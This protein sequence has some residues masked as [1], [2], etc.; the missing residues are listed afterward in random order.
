[1]DKLLNSLVF[2]KGKPAR[3][4][5]I[6]K[7]KFNLEFLDGSIVK[8]RAKDFRFIYPEFSNVNDEC[9]SI[10]TTI[11]DELQSQQLSLKEITEWLFDEYSAQ[12]AWCSCLLA[13]DG[14]YFYW[15]K[16]VVYIRTKEQ[17]IS[18][19]SKREQQ[20]IEDENIK[21]CLDNIANNTF[22][23]KDIEYIK[24]VEKV[25]LN[26]SKH[27]KILAKLNIKNT[28]ENAH[29]MLLKIGYVDYFF[30][31]YLKRNDILEDED[32][33]DINIAKL[34]RKDLTHIK[35]FSIDSAH[36]KDSDD[37]IGIDDNKIWIHIADVSLVIKSHFELDDYAKQRV[38]SLY[39]PNK[40]FHML[41]PCVTELCALGINRK[42]NA[43]SIGF[44]LSDGEIKDIE[45]THSVIMVEKINYDYADSIIDTNK[46]L[47][48]LQNFANLH[49]NY[50]E[51]KG[52][53]NLNSTNINIKLKDKKIYIDLLKSSKSRELVAEMMIMAGRAVAKCS[54]ENKIV[55][56]YIGQDQVDI[57]QNILDNK[58]NLTLSQKFA[59]LKNFKKSTASINN[60]AHY[61]LGLD[62][63]LR[64]TSPLR[65]YLDLLAHQQLSNFIAGNKTLDNDDVKQIIGIIN[66]NSISVNMAIRFSYEHFKCL[67]LIQNPNWTG[68]GVVL[69]IVGNKTILA[70][71]SLDMRTYINFKKPKKLDEK[72]LLKVINVNLV[73]RLVDFS[74]A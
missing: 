41:P 20:L 50:R 45:I 47:L 19:K 39:L 43:L 42:S 58:T 55:M 71:P 29:R 22:A 32:I 23:K 6:T 21:N 62:S 74:P 52:A 60:A 2:F 25:A 54:L 36:T 8:A 73:E 51:S 48:K 28:P 69:D 57:P 15:K 9:K 30:N 27:S 53:I 67:Y 31:P 33:D 46:Y 34:T 18:I 40:T 3:V 12:N 44:V 66:A 10:D 61:G 5:E 7:N 65:R 59:V 24:E 63:Y 37:A 35:S 72:I 64:I 4:S 14:L 17:I 13:V 16:D 68:I 70:I 11:L 56:P 38:S 49:R 26:K 1:L